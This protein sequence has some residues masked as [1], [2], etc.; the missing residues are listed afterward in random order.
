MM[1]ADELKKLDDT[2][3]AKRAEREKLM[4]TVK[5]MR[6]KAGKLSA[7]IAA[8]ETNLPTPKQRRGITMQADPAKVAMKPR[9]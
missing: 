3:A 4:L 5:D 1:T 2:V 9:R 7:E 6:A 8:L